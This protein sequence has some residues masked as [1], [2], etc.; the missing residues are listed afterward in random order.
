MEKM[1]WVGWGCSSQ[2]MDKLGVQMI[3]IK[4]PLEFEIC[5]SNS[6]HVFLHN[7]RCNFENHVYKY[8]KHHQ[9]L[10]APLHSFFNFSAFISL[11]FIDGIKLQK[12]GKIWMRG[13]N[14]RSPLPDSRETMG[15][16]SFEERL[17]GKNFLPILAKRVNK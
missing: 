16:S 11:F 4:V 17:R 10:F 14:R 3:T 12:M 6:Y 13:W 9:I 8:I 15:K 5:Y 7:Y 2:T 1:Y